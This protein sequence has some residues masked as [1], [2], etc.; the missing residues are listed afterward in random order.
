[1]ATQSNS[2]ASKAKSEKPAAAAAAAK[3]VVKAA[4]KPATKPGKR[5]P[6]QEEIGA[7][8][9]EIYVSEGCPEGYSVEHWLRAE[10]ELRSQR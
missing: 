1:M 9:F 8:A 4:A 10:Q 2:K 7:R 3:P 5:E 6:T